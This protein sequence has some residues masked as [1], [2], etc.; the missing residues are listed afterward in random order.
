MIIPHY[1]DRFFSPELQVK[2]LKTKLAKKA[3]HTAPTEPLQ[4]PQTPVD[5]PIHQLH[6]PL[7]TSEQVLCCKAVIFRRRGKKMGF[8]LLK[9]Q[10]M[11]ARWLGLRCSRLLL[12]S[13]RRCF[14]EPGLRPAGAEQPQLSTADGVGKESLPKSFRT[15][16]APTPSMEKWASLS[17]VMG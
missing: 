9:R 14:G 10:S 5:S 13:R 6:Y 2:I 3:S 7:W 16:P 8:K 17:T 11:F 15:K 1:C 12:W 4:N